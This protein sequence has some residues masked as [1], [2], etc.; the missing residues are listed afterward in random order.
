MIFHLILGMVVSD[1]MNHLA[2]SSSWTQSGNAIKIDKQASTVKFVD[3]QVC[4]LVASR[5]QKFRGLFL[6]V[7][8]VHKGC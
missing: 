5:H 4:P 2:L 6:K 7:A 3:L 1:Q 8:K